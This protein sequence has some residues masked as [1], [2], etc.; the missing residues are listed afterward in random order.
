MCWFREVSIHELQFVLGD[1]S[2]LHGPTP[3][4]IITSVKLHCDEHHSWVLR[5]IH[6]MK[7]KQKTRCRKKIEEKK[8][9]RKK[10]KYHSAMKQ[11]GT[12]LL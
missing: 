7:R 5:Q 2:S 12:S 8:K 9:T 3:S 1:E 10:K 11:S 6:L 4:V